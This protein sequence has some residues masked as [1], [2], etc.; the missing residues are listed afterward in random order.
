MKS[1][2]A[3]LFVAMFVALAVLGLGYAWWTEALTINGTVKTGKLEVQFD[4]DSLAKFCSPEMNCEAAV[5]SPTSIEINV[6]NAYPCGWCNIT[7]TINNTG[8]IPAKVK[9][10]TIP[11][12]TGLSISIEGLDVGQQIPVGGSVSPTLKIHVTD[13]ATETT[14]YTFTVTI[15]FK[16]FNA[17]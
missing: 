11:T 7:F 8:T 2:V 12:V 9:A 3:A 10:I 1:K 4:N 13:N 15:E 17:P 6:T 14:T 16:Q 5:K